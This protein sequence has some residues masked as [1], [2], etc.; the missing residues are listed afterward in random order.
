MG[1]LLVGTEDQLGVRERGEAG[2]ASESEIEKEAGS[3]HT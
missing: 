1:V 2:S 3:L